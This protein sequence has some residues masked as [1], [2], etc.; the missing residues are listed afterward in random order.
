MR[1]FLLQQ[2]IIFKNQLAKYYFDIKK[3]S[4]VFLSYS[5]DI[6]FFI[7]IMFIDI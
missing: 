5:E 3:L 7:L 2:T 1:Q 4:I 6:F